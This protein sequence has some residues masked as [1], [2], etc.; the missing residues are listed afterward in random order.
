MRAVRSASV[1]LRGSPHSQANLWSNEDKQ[2]AKACHPGHTCQKEMMASSCCSK[3]RTFN[4][5][6]KCMQQISDLQR[7]QRVRVVHSEH[8]VGALA[9]LQHD[10][11]FV[12]LVHQ[13]KVLD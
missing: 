5:T 11:V 13:L 3:A 7:A 9:K 4:S 8:I 1:P 12:T 2:I 6:S 10:S